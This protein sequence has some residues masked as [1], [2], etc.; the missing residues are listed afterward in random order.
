MKNNH[1]QS[2]LLII[3]V[4]IFSGCSKKAYEFKIPKE[5][6]VKKIS[7]EK[8]KSMNSKQLYDFLK[9]RP[10]KHKDYNHEI[11]YVPKDAYY[12]I[13]RFCKLKN[14]E[15][16]NPGAGG[17]YFNYDRNYFHFGDVELLTSNIILSDRKV[18]GG[19]INACYIKNND[20]FIQLINVSSYSTQFY[21]GKDRYADYAIT[22]SK[23]A[24]KKV[25][26][27]IKEVD[28]DIKKEKA[29]R[30]AADNKYKNMI[31]NLQNRK[32]SYTFNFYDDYKYRGNET[33]KYNC[34]STCAKLNRESTG[35]LRL[36]EALNDNWKLISRTRVL[37][38]SIN[39]NCLCTGIQVI[40][41]K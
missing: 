12:V 9:V 35:Y 31:S 7:D 16:V 28:E 33:D 1:I 8:L 15:M 2:C 26:N 19:A 21:G 27:Y 18:R 34:N 4:L 6:K 11:A 10:F 37:N 20:D 25:K 41:K 40:L 24:K 38:D 13:K 3:S 22:R 32:G 29:R 39:Y 14:G 23:L 17:K 5:V 36:N 30:Q